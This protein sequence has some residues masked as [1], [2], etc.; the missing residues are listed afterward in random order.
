MM[1]RSTETVRG[2]RPRKT[3]PYLTRDQPSMARVRAIKGRMEMNRT[4]AKCG[5]LSA[6]FCHSASGEKMRFRARNIL[7]EPLPAAEGHGMAFG[8]NAHGIVPPVRR[9]GKFDRV[10]LAFLFEVRDAVFCGVVFGVGPK[11]F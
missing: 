6:A 9:D 8:R 10:G 3:S 5:G 7:L 2:A 4:V 1:A 11:I